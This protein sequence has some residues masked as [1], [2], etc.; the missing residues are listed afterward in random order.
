MS[1][2]LVIRRTRGAP[3]CPGG[4]G[5]AAPGVRFRFACLSNLRSKLPVRR[6][7]RQGWVSSPARAISFS[8]QPRNDLL[9]PRGG[10]MTAASTPPG[11]TLYRSLCYDPALVSDTPCLHEVMDFRPPFP[12]RGLPLRG[13]VRRKTRAP[14]TP[15]RLLHGVIRSCMRSQP[16]LLESGKG[17]TSR[18]MNSCALAPRREGALLRER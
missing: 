18:S 13:I 16:E 8:R 11:L 12:P 14:T 15:A 6:A 3:L 2:H 17:E 7:K 9:A 1:H 4:L 5:R 10:L